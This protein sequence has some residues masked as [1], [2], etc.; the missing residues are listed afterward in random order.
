MGRYRHKSFITTGSLWTIGSVLGT[1]A[2]TFPS[3]NPVTSEVIKDMI[4]VLLSMLAGL[5]C[6][7][8]PSRK[9]Y[10]LAGIFVA[11]LSLFSSKPFADYLAYFVPPLYASTVTENWSTLMCTGNAISHCAPE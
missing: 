10:V 9:N 7:F 5:C 3:S 1:V 11:V 6:S 4:Y 2:S 8:V